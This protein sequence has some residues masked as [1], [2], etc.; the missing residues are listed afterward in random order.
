MLTMN[1]EKY[2]TPNILQT[3]L[4]KYKKEINEFF[5][6]CHYEFMYGQKRDNCG[7]VAAGFSMFME[8][9][10]A[11]EKSLHKPDSY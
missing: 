4:S 9:K 6:V 8:N 3:E 10:N 1:I 5:K 2:L 11:Y 7:V